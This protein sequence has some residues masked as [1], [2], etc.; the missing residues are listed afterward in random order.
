[1]EKHA[2]HSPGHLRG[3][4]VVGF[5][6]AILLTVVS[7]GIVALGVQPQWLAVVALVVAATVQIFVHLRYFLHLDT[8][9]EMTWNLVSIV[10]TALIVFIFI[11][12]T[13]WVIF[14]L[15]ARMM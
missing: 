1:M 2:D 3:Q 14:T 15:N 6:L 13:V 9:K 11:A 8:S 7:F 12:G 5:I 10:F 4:Y